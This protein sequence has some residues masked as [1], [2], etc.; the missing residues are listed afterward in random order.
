MT[1]TLAWVRS[2]GGIDEMV[3]ASDSR[4]RPFA[5]DVAPK[6]M[7]LPRDDSIVAFAGGTDYA[8]PMM[9][10]MVNTVASWGKAANRGQ[11]LEELKG[12]LVRV[13]N[14]MLGEMTDPPKFPVVPDAF[15]LLAGF[16]WKSQEFRIWTLHFDSN[17]GGFTFR[18]ASRWTGG[19]E[20]KVLAIV[21]DHID[22]AKDRLTEL[23]KEEGKLTSGGFD[24]EPFQVLADIV[25]SQEFDSI[26]GQ[27]QLVKIYRHLQVVPFVV[28][29]NG[30][31]SLL[32]RPL[33]DYEKPDR[34]PALVW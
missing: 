8:Y 2:V 32:G 30:V 26:G 11:P 25:D 15:F 33:L 14:R 19:N 9:I 1:L 23:L 6:I 31:R 27:L 10:Q 12:H 21:G 3:V 20:A 18:P 7:P 16:S 24:M 17:L 34:F 22:R 4:L 28:D 29:R 5:W 13:L